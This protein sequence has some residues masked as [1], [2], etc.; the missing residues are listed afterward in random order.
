MQSISGQLSSYEIRRRRGRQIWP[1]FGPGV[2]YGPNNRG[3]SSLWGART[4]ETA[5]SAMGGTGRA[6]LW[7]VRSAEPRLAG[8]LIANGGGASDENP[9]PRGIKIPSTTKQCQT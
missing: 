6:G 1:P 4:A 2:T 7:G 8:W 9:P 3:I 5:G